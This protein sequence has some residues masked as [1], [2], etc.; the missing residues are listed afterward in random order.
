LKSGEWFGFAEVRIE[1]PERLK[2]MLEEMC[3]FYYNKHVPTKAVLQHMKEYLTRTGRQYG[4]GRKLVGA[5]SA[6][7]MLV[8]APLL[9]W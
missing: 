9:R 5:L 2:P 4:D 3:R 7:R 8:Y 6:E 1:I